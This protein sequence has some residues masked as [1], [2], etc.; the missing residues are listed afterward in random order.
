MRMPEPRREVPNP[1]ILKKSESGISPNPCAAVGASRRDSGRLAMADGLP[2]DRGTSA[3]R[4]VFDLHASIM[5]RMPARIASGKILIHPLPPNM[6]GGRC[7]NADYRPDRGP[8]GFGQRRPR[9]YEG[10]QVRVEDAPFGLHLPATETR[11][12]DDDGAPPSDAALDNVAQLADELERLIERAEWP[13]L[14]PDARAEFAPAAAAGAQARRN[15]DAPDLSG[16]GS[17]VA[18]DRLAAGVRALQ[19]TWATHATL[20]RAERLLYTA[21]AVLTAADVPPPIAF[22]LAPSRQHP[23]AIDFREWTI[24]IRAE[25]RRSQAC[26]PARSPRRWRADWWA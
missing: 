11:F 26:T 12:I 6:P 1:G 3:T 22:R 21:Q 8:D 15:G 10:G 16:V 25:P 9:G 4:H 24:L 5:A 19:A 17:V 20:D 18:M 23:A 2:C 14:R 7:A 13:K